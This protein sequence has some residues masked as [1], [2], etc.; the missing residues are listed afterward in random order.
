MSAAETKSTMPHEKSPSS[1]G[2]TQPSH[3]AMLIA[4][5]AMFGSSFLFI[6]LAVAS[7]SPLLIVAGRMLVAS[8]FLGVIVRI[9][10]LSLPR[11][12]G[13]GGL[14]PFSRAWSFFIA[15]AI[16]GNLLPFFLIGWGQQQVPSSLAGI[17]VSIM[18]I[19]TALLA[20]WIIG[21]DRLTRAKLV[22]FIVG[23]SGIIVLFGPEA[24]GA[25]TAAPIWAQCL[26]LGAA[27]CYAVNTVLARLAPEVHP[28]AAGFCVTLAAN[29]LIWPPT[30]LIDRPWTADPSLTAVLSTIVLGIFPTGLAAV[31]YFRLVRAAGASFVGLVNYLVP[32]FAV[33]LGVVLLDE[34]LTWNAYLALA[35]VLSGIGLTQWAERRRARGKAA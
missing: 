15:I 4:L 7:L 2:G 34:R 10:G 28:V 31:V 16:A 35:I 13:P 32:P 1:Q 22:G 12:F 8:L 26:I 17:L 14:G 19:V 25:V 18:P 30:I 27:C 5:M 9:M 29:I 23:F 24:L 3:W 11:V 6:E 20:H 21:D 33:L